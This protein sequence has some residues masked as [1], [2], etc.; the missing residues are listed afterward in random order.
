MKIGND[1]FA[2]INRDDARLIKEVASDAGDMELLEICTHYLATRLGGYA[3]RSPRLHPQRVSPELLE[4]LR[5]LPV[6]VER[7]EKPEG[8]L[9]YSIG[10]FNY[11]YGLGL[12][13]R[14]ATMLSTAIDLG[15]VRLESAPQA[16]RLLTALDGEPRVD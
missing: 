16:A 14:V 10:G 4:E 3:K 11:V 15:T 6:Q 2:R 1:G 5:E 13:G 12:M 8:G 9:D 7:M